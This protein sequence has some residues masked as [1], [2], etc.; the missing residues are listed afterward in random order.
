VNK[1]RWGIKSKITRSL[2]YFLAAVFLPV[3]YAIR[4]LRPKYYFRFGVIRSDVLG[5]SV[6]DPVFY[7]N[8]KQYTGGKEIDFFYFSRPPGPNSFWSAF[9]KKNIRICRVIR[10]MHLANTIFLKDETLVVSIL[11]N[12]VGDDVDR[13]QILTKVA[14]YPKFSEA[15]NK[16][17]R[18]FLRKIGVQPESKFICLIVRDAHYKARY[19]SHI[20][21]DWDY[22]DFRNSDIDSFSDAIT[23]L[24]ERGY[25]VIRMGKGAEKK[26][27]VNHPRMYD[28]AFSE[29]RSDFLDIWLMANTFFTVSTG[30]GLDTVSVVYQRPVVYV[31]Y[32]PV[33]LIASYVK[34]I[35]VPKR[36]FWKEDSVELTL[37]ESLG[38]CY[39]T[40]LDYR[41][42]GIL[43]KDL[44]SVE[45]KEAILE[46][47]SRL[48][49]QWQDNDGTDQDR[50]WEIIKRWPRFASYHGARHPEARIGA[51][52]LERRGAKY[53]N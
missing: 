53:L 19:Q 5:H 13:D 36:L 23:S 30:T 11:G 2:D 20:K 4:R 38:H 10:Y 9:I 17:G 31:D 48:K 3:V 43:V 41:N 14:W 42:A 16:V 22:G 15:Q 46:M 51:G 12:S 25:S 47:E 50:A 35:T 40:S 8:H 27:S 33:G 7:L 39:Q 26:C 49:G 45:K 6:F 44:S 29:E 28:Y 34:S 18:Q 52:F 37:A 1:R 32:I 21:A 24:L